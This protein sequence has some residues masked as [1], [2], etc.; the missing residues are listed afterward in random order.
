VIQDRL[1]LQV[2]QTLV[3]SLPPALY[4]VL[5]S[6]EDPDLPLARLRANNQLTEIRAADLRFSPSES[7]HFLNQVMG[8]SLSQDNVA[9]LADKTEGWVAGLQLAGLS[10]RDQAAPTSFIARL[11]WRWPD[12]GLAWATTRPCLSLRLNNSSPIRAAC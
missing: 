9:M 6:R 3:S 7:A 4:L 2:L 12:M 5:L 11:S 10:L 1:V 8:L